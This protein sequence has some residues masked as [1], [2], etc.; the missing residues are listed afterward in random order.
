MN[1]LTP[2]D[3]HPDPAGPWRIPH[4][5][6]PH[7]VDPVIYATMQHIVRLINA[8]HAYNHRVTEV[9]VTLADVEH[10]ARAV[11]TS[12][13]D[14]LAAALEYEAERMASLGAPPPTYRNRVGTEWSRAALPPGMTRNQCLEQSTAY[15]QAAILVRNFVRWTPRPFPGTSDVV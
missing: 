3:D 9:P 1:P 13:V 14:L 11:L 6:L 7:D 5:D 4:L 12:L 15:A 10:T 2:D 8:H